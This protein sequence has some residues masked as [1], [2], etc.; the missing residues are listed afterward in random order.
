MT[1]TS[2]VGRLIARDHSGFSMMELLVVVAIIGL[3]LALGLP[4][5]MGSRESARN[6]TCRN[7]LKQLGIAL[8]NHH[9]Q[10][11]YLP[12][13]GERGWGFGVFILPQLD[14]TPLFEQ[15][16]PLTANLPSGSAAQPE[17]TGVALRVFRCPSFTVED[18]TAAGFGRST[19]RGNGA[20]FASR[21]ELTDVI[22]GESNTLV[23]VEATT[24]HGWALPGTVG[25]GDLPN[26]GGACGSHHPGGANG[27]L[28][29]GSVRFLR[30]DIDASIYKALLTPAGRESIG[31][32]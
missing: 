27:V 21:T 18:R 23:V 24:D 7:Q 22:D 5:I 12:R 13:D 9:G 11:G 16:Q 3:L 25:G 26:Q 29:D 15:L 8:Q 32:W 14:Q 30:N 2:P 4:A 19:Y 6:A 20:I 10:F 28:C 31:D 1:K 17:T